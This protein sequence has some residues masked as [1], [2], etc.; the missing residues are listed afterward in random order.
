MCDRF[1]ALLRYLYTNE[2]EFAPWGSAERRKARAH[3]EI[4]ESYEP[5]K[6]SPKSIYRLADKVGINPLHSHHALELISPSVQHPQTEGARVAADSTRSLQVRYC[7][8]GFQQVHIS[9]RHSIILRRS[10]FSLHCRY[11]EL[12]ELELEQLAHTLLSTDSGPVLDALKDKIKVYTRGKLP[13]AKEIL[14]ALY[15]LME[16]NEPFKKTPVLPFSFFKSRTAGRDWKR[17]KDALTW[18]LTSGSFLDSQ[19]YALDS[20][21]P[22]DPSKFRPIYF[23]SMASGIFSSKLV[24]RGFCIR[25]SYEYR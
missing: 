7:G 24:K 3:G 25:E 1:Q 17:L 6:P 21:P 12:R 15:G 10:G 23:C 20:R 22:A 16:R 18:S 9:V 5:P 8:R 2:I 13:H 4:T 14:T 11:P 19:F